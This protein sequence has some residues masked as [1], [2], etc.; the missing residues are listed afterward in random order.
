MSII[1]LQDVTV[2]FEDHTVLKSI[3][4]E[5][6]AGES[7]VIVGPSGQGK[8]TLLK[9]MAGLVTPQ[10]GKVFVEQKEWIT[11]G[12]KER[13]SVLKKV[14]ILF[15]KNALF[16]SLT[17]V[18][19]ISFPLRET[20]EL[21]DWE[22]TKKAEYFL[23]AVGIPH[24]RDLYPDEISGGMQKRLGIARALALD[25]EIIFYDDPTAGLDPITS[26]KIIELVLKLKKE[27]GSTIVAITNDMNRAF[28]MADRIGVVVDQELII[29]GNPEQTKNHADPRVHQFV[30]GLLQG[31]LTTAN[32]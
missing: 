12:R 26:R 31:P 13:L 25:P 6:P 4:L 2:S 21:S 32:V 17:C 18:Q 5:I 23:D 19:N 10:N 11:L 1:S 27:K 30:R 24:A 9:V 15:Q 22:I 3:H 8:T 16:D 28:Q 14:G 29:T 7:F 20:T